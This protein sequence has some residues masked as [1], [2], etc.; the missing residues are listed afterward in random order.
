MSHTP[1]T[2]ADEVSADERAEADVVAAVKAAPN[3]L[4]ARLAAAAFALDPPRYN[5]ADV[6]VHLNAVPA[7]QRQTLKVKYLEG[8][9]GLIE[10]K[11]ISPSTPGRGA[12]VHRRHRR[13][14]DRRPRPGFARKRPARRGAPLDRTISPLDRRHVVISPGSGLLPLFGGVSVRRTA[15]NNGRAAG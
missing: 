13:C 8:M 11:P 7:D 1:G 3:N 4:D 9:I 6:R 5:A 15:R 14:P 2:P 10:S 12:A